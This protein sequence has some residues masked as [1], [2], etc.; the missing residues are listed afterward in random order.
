[1]CLVGLSR[2]ILQLRLCVFSSPGNV[3]AFSFFFFF[4]NTEL[5][6]KENMLVLQGYVAIPWGL[7]P[8]KFYTADCRPM[9]TT[10]LSSLQALVKDPSLG[11]LQRFCF[12]LFLNA[13]LYN[14][15]SNTCNETKKKI[16]APSLVF[17]LSFFYTYI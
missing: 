15:K 9:I 13:L 3:S 7:I 14:Y 6:R 12:V 8:G 4:A 16:T 1:M 11:I 10:H 17:F 5:T 2:R